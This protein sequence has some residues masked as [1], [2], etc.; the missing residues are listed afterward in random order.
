MEGRRLWTC[1]VVKSE[2]VS[3]VT[4]ED[5]VAEATRN[6]RVCPM[7]DAWNRL[8]NL[9]PNHERRAGGPSLPLILAAWSDTPHEAKI[10]RVREHLEWAAKYGV[11]VEAFAYLR[12]GLREDHWL[13]LGDRP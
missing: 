8:F 7:P 5:A 11:L 1:S 10:L 9:L 2:A 3:E 4:F 6:Q 13:H 12:G